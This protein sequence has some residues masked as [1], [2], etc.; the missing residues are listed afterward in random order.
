MQRPCRGVRC[1]HKVNTD[2]SPEGTCERG[3]AAWER[4]PVV[5]LSR[6][7]S[8]ARAPG[9]GHARATVPKRRSS[10]WA[11]GWGSGPG[12]ASGA[13]TRLVALMRDARASEGAGPGTR[14][15]WH[16]PRRCE[17]RT[18]EMER[19][20]VRSKPRWWRRLDGATA[21]TARATAGPEHGHRSPFGFWIS[22]FVGA[23]LNP[24]LAL[25]S[26]ISQA[27]L[28]R[29]ENCD[30]HQKAPGENE[31]CRSHKAPHRSR[32][33]RRQQRLHLP[34]NAA[35]PCSSQVSSHP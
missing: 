1:E 18:E 20:P 13:S 9:R 21:E 10:R 28:P 35:A 29:E 31:K 5:P 27:V 30:L 33:E 14:R 19:A 4:L 2:F 26:G 16:G 7:E 11:P 17:P 15:P 3:A 12:P 32:R 34:R 24:T 8:C 22:V 23:V 25:H 6:M